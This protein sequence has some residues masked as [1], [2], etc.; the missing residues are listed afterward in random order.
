MKKEK[1]KPILIISALSGAISYGMSELYDPLKIF[2][3][4]T[5][6]LMVYYYGI[7]SKT[8]GSDEI[9]KLLEESDEALKEMEGVIVE[10]RE[11]IQDYEKIFDGQVATLDC[12]CGGNTFE[13]IFQPGVENVVECEKCGESYKVMVSFDSIL[14]SKP[15][16]NNE[17]LPQI[18][19]T[20]K[21]SE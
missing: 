18:E 19:A 8:K 6:A 2:A 21:E 1:I 16:E 4:S 14:I 15:L 7:F 20:I 10:Q 17:V 3:L 11:V 5:T 12:N 13:G 9:M